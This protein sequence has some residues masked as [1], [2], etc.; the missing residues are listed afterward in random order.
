ML[1]EIQINNIKKTFKDSS[2]LK[3]FLEKNNLHINK[4]GKIFKKEAGILKLPLM[5]FQRV[6][7]EF[8]NR[9]SGRALI[10]DEMGLGKSCESIAFAEFTDSK[11]LIIAPKSVILQWQRE[12][13]KFTGKKST[14]WDTKGQTGSLENQYHIVNY[15]AVAK[16]GPQLR[17]NSFKLMICDEATYLKNRKT[18]RSKS[19]LGDLRQ[20]KL[21]PGIKTK[22]VIFLTGT[23]VL[24]RPIE[25]FTLLN[26]LDSQRFNNFFQFTQRYGGWRGDAPRN[27]D[28]LHDR[29]KDLI[30]RRLKKDVF[31]ELPKK[32][33]HSLYIDL[34]DAEIKEYKKL[35]KEL[36]G[37]WKASGKPSVSEMPKIQQYLI[38]KK[39]PRLN[40]ALAEMLE[41]GKKS[42]VYCCYVQPLLDLKKQYGDDAVIIHG[43]MSKTERQE[44]IDELI[45]GTAKIGLFSIGT[46]SMG[47]DGLQH[48]IDTMFFLD[49][50]WT[51]ALHDQA[52][53]R[54]DRF[55]QKSSVTAY[56][57]ICANTIDDYMEKLV[58][59]KRI[60]AETI[61]D[62]KII[63]GSNNKSFFKDFIKLMKNDYPKLL[64]VDTRSLYQVNSD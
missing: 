54:I 23:P 50:A 30:I 5:N 41:Q 21:F 19:I 3:I 45:S 42:L 59:E 55:G 17:Q 22:Y 43:K 46:G 37:A 47:I 35:L 57:I 27:L 12:I 9:V 28:D 39:I 38:S 32:Q 51:G 24:N 13:L 4:A 25:A 6:G 53:A 26:F 33:R 10:A 49:F 2:D 40:E 34:S 64:K 29:T 8:I 52:E 36:F 56:Y 31:K 58:S 62:G 61:V 16:I 18:N 1:I 44:A 11:T 20:K 14:V 48:A 7:V 63:T 15:E 60:I